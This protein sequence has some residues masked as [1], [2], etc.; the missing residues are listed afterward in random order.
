MKITICVP[1]QN[2]I[3]AIQTTI[4]GDIL[5]IIHL[6]GSNKFF[7]LE[8]RPAITPNI[9]PTKPQSKILIIALFAVIQTAFQ[10]VSL[11]NISIKA[12]NV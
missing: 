8:F 6:I 2:H 10:N 3:I 5:I 11:P 12:E 9:K 1:I 7:I 4:I